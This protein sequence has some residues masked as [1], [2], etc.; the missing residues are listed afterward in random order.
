M[1][2]NKGREERKREIG[3]QVG[4][5]GPGIEDDPEKTPVGMWTDSPSGE[6]KGWG[7]G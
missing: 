1:G 6:V 2:F 7:R 3:G 4:N 5:P